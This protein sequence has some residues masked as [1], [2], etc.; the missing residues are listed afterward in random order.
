L[1]LILGSYDASLAVASPSMRM[2][3]FGFSNYLPLVINILMFFLFRGF[4]LEEK[5]PQLRK[6]I[7]NRRAN[8]SEE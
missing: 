7:E 4:D 5:L 8:K 2:S 3:I 1:F 6:E